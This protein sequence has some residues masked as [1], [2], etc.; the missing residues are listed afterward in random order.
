MRA[1]DDR[2]CVS[3]QSE[4]LTSTC[5]SLAVSSVK[6]RLASEVG[7]S[8]TEFSYQL[9]Q[10]QDFLHLHLQHGCA[11]QLGGSDQWGNIIAGIDLI[12]RHYADALPAPDA[13]ASAGDGAAAGGGGSNSSKKRKAAAQKAAR[14]ERA[15]GLTIP[16]LTTASGEK[17]GK[18][19]GNAV[20]LD[21]RL[22]S[23][24]DFY[25]VRARGYSAARWIRGSTLTA[26]PLPPFQFFYRTTDAD[27]GRYLKLFTL[28]SLEQIEAVLAK[29]AVRPPAERREAAPLLPL[30]AM[31]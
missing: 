21:E 30:A 31:F 24:F 23:L 25:Q 17:F 8:F 9:L 22:T 14:Q 3:E 1:P 28:L 27:V 12:H 29:H 16:L 11:V 7:I 2:A 6:S 18:S 19:A 5:P 13:G 26:G 4:R 15:F 10:A 20:W